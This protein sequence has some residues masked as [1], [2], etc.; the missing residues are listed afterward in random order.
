MPTLD[1]SLSESKWIPGL[2]HEIKSIIHGISPD[3]EISSPLLIVVLQY[4]SDTQF[5]L[6]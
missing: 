5:I 1:F 4:L 3:Q 2:E 6:F